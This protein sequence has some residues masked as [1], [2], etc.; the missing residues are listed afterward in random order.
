MNLNPM[1]IMTNSSI[2][3][4][5]EGKDI[6]R[7]KSKNSQVVMKDSSILAAE[8]ENLK[9][10]INK[11]NPSS[12][13]KDLSKEREKQGSS[14]AS[15]S[16]MSKKRSKKNILDGNRGRNWSRS[17]SKSRR[18]RNTL[19]KSNIVK[20][21]TYR[22]ISAL[23][24]NLESTSKSLV[25]MRGVMKNN[26]KSI[27]SVGSRTLEARDV[28]LRGLTSAWILTCSTLMTQ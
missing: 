9:N 7:K 6:K 11:K 15:N 16:R 2:L 10:K 1:K 14:L 20:E 12:A 22:S 5:T 24:L 28:T 8:R 23:K 17:R 3:E 19:K 26:M 25:M 27:M 13:D 4:A 21:S 18:S